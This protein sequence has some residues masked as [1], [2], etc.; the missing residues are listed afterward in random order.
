MHTIGLVMMAAALV[1]SG[2]AIFIAGA[3]VGYLYSNSKENNKEKDQVDEPLQMPPQTSEEIKED[4]D[5]TW[6]TLAYMGVSK[7]LG[8]PQNKFRLSHVLTDPG[9]GK[10]WTS[11]FQL[12]VEEAKVPISV[13]VCQRTEEG[14][15]VIKIEVCEGSAAGEIKVL[16]KYTK[17][18]L[19]SESK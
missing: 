11:Y 4:K 17:E 1:L 2:M 6:Q 16:G 13:C 14:E 15:Q 19:I 3:L 8:I 12:R 18:E 5:F 9:E 10:G 7:A